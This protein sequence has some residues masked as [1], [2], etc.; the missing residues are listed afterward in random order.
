MSPV[1]RS[2]F[3]RTCRV[4]RVRVSFFPSLPTSL[5]MESHSRV[6]DVSKPGGR[7]SAPEIRSIFS[8]FAEIRAVYP[9]KSFDDDVEHAFVEFRYTF[10]EDRCAR[11]ALETGFCVASLQSQQALRARFDALLGATQGRPVPSFHG[12]RQPKPPAH[13]HLDRY[14]YSKLEANTRTRPLKS[15]QLDQRAQPALKLHSHPTE[16]RGSGG[17]I[18]ATSSART[19]SPQSRSSASSAST[20]HTSITETLHSPSTASAIPSPAVLPL[21]PNHVSLTLRDTTGGTLLNLGNGFALPLASLLADSKPV[22]DILNH[23]NATIGAFLVVAREYKVRNML[24][25][26][27]DVATG[28]V[29]STSLFMF[30][31]L[32]SQT[33]VVL[34]DRGDS[35]GAKPVYIFISSLHTARAKQCSPGGAQPLSMLMN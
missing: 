20:A 6:V 4:F 33:V 2:S 22:I 19:S 14:A 9:W 34:L 24:D 8:R 3:D 1:R 26:A 15:E 18:Q 10:P 7:H 31:A 13:R 28:A 29:Q 21:P 27:H 17:H 23:N 16:R 25:Q 5:S 30:L 35:N 11:M 32:S 12:P